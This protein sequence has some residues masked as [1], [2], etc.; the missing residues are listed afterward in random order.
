MKSIIYHLTIAIFIFGFSACNK[1][2]NTPKLIVK[3]SFDKNQERLDNFGEPATIAAGNAAQT[4]IFRKLGVHSLELINTP[5]VLPNEG[6]ILYTGAETTAGG[7]KAIDFEKEVLLEEGSILAEI[8]LNEITPGTYTYL[9]NSLAYQEY[10]IAVRVNHSSGTYDLNS[11]LA[12]FIGFNT[13]IKSH[14]LNEES[15]VVNGNK[16]QG[17]WAV[18]TNTA[19]GNFK[20]TG[21]AAGTTVPNILAD[22][23]PIPLNSCLVTGAFKTPLKITGEET[24]DI[25]ITVKISINNSFEWVDA[26][27]NGIYE[28]GDGETVVDMG[29]RGLIVE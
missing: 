21:Q 23:S 26:N 9:R 7:T 8:P 27:D 3:Y 11:R 5:Y 14:T 1:E 28:P 15:F 19:A 24:E 12:S 25:T 4:P 18:E 17:Y 20:E 6:S 2:N 22:T 10:D 13:Y 29:V 16:K